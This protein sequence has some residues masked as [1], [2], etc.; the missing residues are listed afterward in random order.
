MKKE[1]III[2]KFP[3]WDAAQDVVFAYQNYLE[4]RR[5]VKLAR[6]YGMHDVVHEPNLKWKSERLNKVLKDHG[7]KNVSEAQ[8]IYTAGNQYYKSLKK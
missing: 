2:K 4:A 3:R 8:K 6:K 1:T 7:F 5:A